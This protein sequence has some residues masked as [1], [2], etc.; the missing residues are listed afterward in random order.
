MYAAL[1]HHSQRSA[2]SPDCF[3]YLMY[4]IRQI[5]LLQDVLHHSRVIQIQRGALLQQPH[6]HHLL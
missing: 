5:H 4:E 6:F 2:K 1:L 3:V